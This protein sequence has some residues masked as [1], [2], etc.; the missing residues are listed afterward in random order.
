MSSTTLYFA[1]LNLASEEIYRIYKDPKKH[2]ELRFALS[3][4]LRR[5]CQ[6]D[7]ESFFMGDDGIPVVQ[8]VEYKLHTLAIDE[9][10][11]YAE[12]WVYKKST[13]RY[14]S[15]IEETRELIAKNVEN[16]E[17]IR[18]Y[19]DLEHE[20]VG[21]N[22]T[23]R[24]GYK[25]FLDAFIHIIN[26]GLDGF[27]PEMFFTISLCS[28]GLGLEDIKEALGE[29]GKIKELQFRIQPPN[30]AQEL[31]DKLQELGEGRL[32]NMDQA[33][34]TRMD[35]TFQSTGESGLN[36]TS[37][38]IEDELNKLQGIH[39]ALPPEEANKNGY[40]KVT[41][42]SKSGRKFSSE[43]AK[44]FKKVINDIV[45][46]FKDACKDAFTELLS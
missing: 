31:L 10:I 19:F 5:E 33:N 23:N 18:F 45:S 35:V 4:S 16:T 8:T 44:P 14:N 37:S 3:E 11:S 12:G 43:E 36:L 28:K 2:I 29:I 20:F 27:E 41:A 21:Y 9:D 25:E 30:P 1:K 22:T 6:W 39:Q 42:V 13:L 46:E 32:E 17:A 15:L 26:H 24:F 38:L 40:I 7:K 34:V